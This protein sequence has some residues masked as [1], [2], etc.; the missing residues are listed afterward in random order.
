M[1]SLSSFSFC[2]V[3]FFSSKCAATVLICF[4]FSSSRIFLNEELVSFEVLS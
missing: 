2:G 3:K 4:C 1:Y